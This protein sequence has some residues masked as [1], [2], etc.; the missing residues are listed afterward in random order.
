MGMRFTF[1]TDLHLSGQTPAH[2]V[3]N[4]Q[5]A[6][7]DKL[8]EVYTVAKANGSDFVVFGGDLFHSHRIFSYELLSPVMDILCD[9]K[10]DTYLVIGQHDILG[11]NPE[12]YRSSTLSFIINRC[13]ALKVLWEPITV[14]CVHLCPSHV[15]QPLAEAANYELEKGKVNVLVAHHL[16]TNKK[17]MFESLSSDDFVKTIKAAGKNF[18]VVVS[19]DLHDGYQTHLVEDTWFCNP[20]SIARRATSDMNRPPKFAVVDVEPGTIPVITEQKVKCAKDGVVV[21]GESIAETMRTEFE[22]DPSAFVKGI[23]EFESE[24]SEVHELVQKV[25]KSKGIRAEVLDYLA[26]KSVVSV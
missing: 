16:I 3:D 14:G 1:Y 20:G 21:F 6:L 13:P 9:S 8:G 24:S 17:T 25:G 2:R 23:E 12:T 11:Y 4:Y 22:F 26:S 18:D 7:V 10:I 19:G 15:W 5:Q